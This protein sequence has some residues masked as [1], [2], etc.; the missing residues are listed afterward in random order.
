MQG[1]LASWSEMPWMPSLCLSVR[2]SVK[3]VNCDKIK[4]KLQEKVNKRSFIPFFWQKEWLVGDDCILK[5][6]VKHT[7]TDPF[8]ANM[9]L[10]YYLVY[11]ALTVTPSKK[12]SINTNRKSTTRF[13]M[14][15]RWTYSPR[16]GSKTH[17]K[18]NTH[19]LRLTPSLMVTAVNFWSGGLDSN[20]QKVIKIQIRR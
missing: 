14:S 12:S 4:R 18:V 8:G 16:G 1:A 10:I 13:L 17:K 6:W 11:S 7:I 20:L 9:P 5:F 3:R 15:L 19:W 2:R